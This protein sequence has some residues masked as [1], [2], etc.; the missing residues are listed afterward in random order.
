[1]DKRRYRDDDIEPSVD[2][3]IKEISRS[4]SNYFSLLSSKAEKESQSFQ[5]QVFLSLLDQ[6]HKLDALFAQAGEEPAE[7]GIVVGILRDLGVGQSKANKSVTSHLSRLEKARD[8]WN[9]PERRLTVDDAVALSNAY[10]V[11]EMVKKWR[12]LQETR[13]AIF[14]PRTQ[15]ESIINAL[16][17]GKELRFDARNNPTVQLR[18]G[19]EVDVGALSSGEKQLFILL[20][21]A[22]LQEERPVVFISDEPELSLHVK[23]Q[24]ALFKHVRALNGSCQII[25]ATHS[26]DI[27][28]QFQQKV[29]K[30]EDCFK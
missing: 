25:S 17:S 15:F 8:H 12:H 19:D 10:R 21:E 22:V 29:I 26:P 20:G 1:L 2:A 7:K 30:I 11:N 9:A 28:G 14:Q 5:E 3:K 13:S 18:N 24:T 27:V 16:F 4:F 23:W 6:E